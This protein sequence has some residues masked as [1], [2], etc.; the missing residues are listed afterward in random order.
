[1]KWKAISEEEV[2][3]KVIAAKERMSLPLQRFW[4]SVFIEPEKWKQRP[5]GDHGNGFWAVAVIGRTV[6]WYNDIEDGFNRSRYS[7]Y[8]EI[9]DYWCN[10]DDLELTV[11]Y[12]FNAIETGYDSGPYAGPPRQGVY[13]GQ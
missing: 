3:D 12:L 5:F 6:V 9:E 4:D 7:S 8:G 13:P 1:M 10:Q 2:W 11:Q